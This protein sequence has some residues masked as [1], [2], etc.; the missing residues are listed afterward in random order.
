LSQVQMLLAEE[1]ADLWESEVKAVAHAAFDEILSELKGGNMLRSVGIV[2]LVK[3]LNDPPRRAAMPLKSMSLLR[4]MG[5]RHLLDKATAAKAAAEH[6]RVDLP[7]V[8]AKAIANAAAKAERLAQAKREAAPHGRESWPRHLP[9]PQGPKPERRNGLPP[10][11]RWEMPRTPAVRSHPQQQQPLRSFADAPPPPLPLAAT[12]LEASGLGVQ[13]P[14][15]RPSPL[16]HA[17]FPVTPGK[18]YIDG[19]WAIRA[20][21]T[22]TSNHQKFPSASRHALQ[23]CCF[24]AAC[25]SPQASLRVPVCAPL[26]VCG[27]GDVWTDRPRAHRLIG[28]QSL[29]SLSLPSH[30]NAI[31]ASLDRSPLQSLSTI[32]AD[33][34]DCDGHDVGDAP[35]H[36]DALAEEEPRPMSEHYRRLVNSTI[37]RPQHPRQTDSF[38]PLTP[39]AS[40][41]FKLHNSPAS[42]NKLPLASP[43][44][45]QS[46]WPHWVSGKGHA[47]EVS[48]AAI[49][50]GSSRIRLYS[51]PC[52]NCM[53][54]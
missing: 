34:G 28:S 3:W 40:A 5:S 51:L 50:F 29:P 49:R 8:H 53:G 10:L 47:S 4:Q 26:D 19:K 20:L 17:R 7:A 32:G 1:S 43:A 33:G 31:A 41:A 45:P 21:L 22:S 16:A 44:P 35:H 6:R 13:W 14:N 27:A 42:L 23:S 2:H 39:H 25:L 46:T 54:V 24:K 9:R 52:R 36:P 18:W 30:T 12:E 15:Q 48:P 38:A 11:Q 37:G